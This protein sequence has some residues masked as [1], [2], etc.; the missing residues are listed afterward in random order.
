MT[1]TFIAGQTASGNVASFDFTN[2]PATFS[3]LELRI[4][5]RGTTSFSAGLTSYLRFND[6]ATAN[7][8]HHNLFGNGTSAFSSAGSST[9]NMDASQVFADSSASANIYG[10]VITSILDYRNTAKSKTIRT[11]GGW[12]GNS[13]SGRVTLASG[14]WQNTGAITK[15]SCLIDGS[16]VAGSRAD[17][18]GITTSDQTG[19]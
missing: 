17:L 8:S 11:I 4:F 16:F 2:I 15:I 5:G 18:Y 12:D 6:D 19:A 13:I 14:A 3:H 10:V 7:Y 9:N 1:M